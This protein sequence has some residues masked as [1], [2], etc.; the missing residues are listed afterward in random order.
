MPR[1]EE[2]SQPHR[3]LLK[4]NWS[5]VEDVIDEADLKINSMKRGDELPNGV[6]QMVKVYVASRR[7]ISVGDKVAGRW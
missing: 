3:K 5:L 2:Q 7:Q 1:Q 4:D 6:L